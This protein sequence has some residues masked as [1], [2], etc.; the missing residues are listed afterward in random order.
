MRKGK[1]KCVQATLGMCLSVC[2]RTPLIIFCFCHGHRG[3]LIKLVPKKKP[4]VTDEGNSGKGVVGGGLGKGGDRGGDRGGGVGGGG[5][6]SC[7]K[8]A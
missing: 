1:G 3:L 8:S 5:G 4:P 7:R 6:A 2:H